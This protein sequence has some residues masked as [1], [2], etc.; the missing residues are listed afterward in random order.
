MTAQ[1]YT[2]ANVSQADVDG[3]VAELADVRADMATGDANAAYTGALAYDL[4]TGA[5]AIKP[6]DHVLAGWTF[7]PANVQAGTIL[8][9]AGLSYVVRVR[10]TFP[11]ITNI[12][13][14]FT[15]GGSALTAGQCF[16]SLHTDAGVLLSSTADQA[17]NWAGGG[18]K[19]MALAA[20]QSVTP[21]QFYRVRFWFNGTTGPTLSRAVNSSSAIV[22]VGLVAPN[23]RYATADAGLTTAVAA[24]TTIGTQTGGA[25]AWWVGLS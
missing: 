9:T 23:F 20:P 1:G 13:L 7:D 14:H 21:G 19:T 8:A 15:A 6:V 16:A 2:G 5:V 10:A 17:A 4:V 25:T 3:L 12:L 22:N 24:P 11:V 18:L